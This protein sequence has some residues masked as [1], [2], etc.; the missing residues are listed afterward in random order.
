MAF[1]AID[2]DRLT[3]PGIAPALQPAA[4]L[5]FRSG[6]VFFVGGS[7]PVYET[8]VTMFES[9]CMAA[10][11]LFF[12]TIEGG[13]GWQNGLEMARQIRKNFPARLVAGVDPR[14][15]PHAVERLYAAGVDNLVFF[16]DRERGAAAPEAGAITAA[17]QV[18]PRWGVGALLP[19][20]DDPGPGH[21]ETMD[22]LLAGGVVPIP[23]LP[24]GR[25]ASEATADALT[26]LIASLEQ[27]GSGVAPYLPLLTTL[28]P[29]KDCRPAGPVRGLIHRLRDQRQLAGSAL[30]RYLRVDPSADSLDSAGL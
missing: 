19:L 16:A 9:H 21:R 2:N 27:A 5:L 10:T 28:A 18:F 4:D 11:A 14:V 23:L 22:Q 13:E 12:L 30:R 7:L 25:T 15:A 3:S 1:L 26:A 17:R 24:A 29:L 6:S 8:L 20:T